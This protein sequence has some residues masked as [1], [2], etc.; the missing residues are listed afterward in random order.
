MQACVRTH[1]LRTIACTLALVAAVGGIAVAH[2]ARAQEAS[3]PVE[4]GALEAPAAL[5]TDKRIAVLPF[6]LN[7]PAGSLRFLSGPLDELLAQ[8]IEAGGEVSAIARPGLEKAGATDLPDASR[9]DAALR[10]WASAQRLDGVV[11]GSLTE[12]AGRFSI[13]VRVVPTALGS[14]ASSLVLTAGS[15][16]ELLDR[17]GELAERVSAAV[18]GGK[19]DRILEIRVEGA[20]SIEA[21]LRARLSLRRGEPFDAARLDADRRVLSQDPRVAR[22]TART[23]QGAEGVVV[24]FEIVRAER[25]LGESVKTAVGA[26]IAEV[27]IRGNR[28]IEEAEIRT[29]IQTAPGQP[30]DP[31]QIA[32]DVRSIFQQ[33]FYRDVQVFVDESAAGPRVVFEVAENPVVREIAISGNDEID[34]DKIKEA[35]TLTTGAPL[36]YPLLRETVERIAAL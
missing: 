3:G 36:D 23:Q 31:G 2:A 27:V 16:R 29:R 15:D 20:E 11:V 6:R 33:G 4:Y 24:V 5:Q 28:R 9:T 34:G 35:L 25:L 13:D 1:R 7:N 18:V 26:A 14:G 12:L 30:V 32:R 19:P 21:E 22:A 10:R 17:L 8:R